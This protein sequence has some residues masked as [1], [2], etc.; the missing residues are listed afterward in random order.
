M[1][2]GLR[3]HNANWNYTASML[4]LMLLWTSFG[5]IEPVYITFPAIADELRAYRTGLY[6]LPCYCR[7]A[8]GI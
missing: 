2:R 1:L 3:F 7:R 6:Y 5:R 8:S 4:P